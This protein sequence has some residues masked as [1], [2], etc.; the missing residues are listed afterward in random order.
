MHSIGQGTH[1]Q[2][3]NG[4]KEYKDGPGQQPKLGVAETEVGNYGCAKAGD[5]RAVDH[6]EYIEQQQKQQYACGF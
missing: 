1:K 4:V 3:H 2:P 5:Q 6:I